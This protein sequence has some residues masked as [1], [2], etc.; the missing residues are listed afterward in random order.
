MGE[1][2]SSWKP[3]CNSSVAVLLSERTTNSDAGAFLLRE[4]L[5]RSGVIESL[6]RQL[7]DDRDPAR[8]QHLCLVSFVLC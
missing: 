7:L 6:G 4:A 1:T 2:L 5:D 8:V 3:T